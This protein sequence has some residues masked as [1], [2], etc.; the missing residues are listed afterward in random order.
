ML[1]RKIA[2]RAADFFTK[3]YV[4]PLARISGRRRDRPSAAALERLWILRLNT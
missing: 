3:F 2:T 1:T 4:V